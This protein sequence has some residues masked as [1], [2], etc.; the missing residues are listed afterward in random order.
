MKKETNV[1]EKK[2]QDMPKEKENIINLNEG[3]NMKKQ[4]ITL[5]IGIL[6][7]AVITTAIFLI[8][9]PKNSRKMPDFSQ[10][11]KNGERVRPNGE[12]FD[13]SKEGRTRS[14]RDN[15]KVDDNKTE[16]TTNEKQG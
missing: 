3:G 6:I 11:E 10:F 15:N 13:F 9:K 4:I 1:L 14:N 8:A 5:V 12:N 7:G 2:D 16:D